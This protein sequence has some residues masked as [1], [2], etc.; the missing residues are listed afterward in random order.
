MSNAYAIDTLRPTATIV[1]AD[2][3]L[4]VGETSLVTISFSEA[5]SG[6]TTSDFFVANG[7]L[8]DLSSSDGGITWTA[9]L[10]PTVGV[11][12]TSNL[13]TLNNSGYADAAGNTGSDI[14]DSNSYAIDTLRPT[15]SIVV[16]DTALKAGDSAL[17]T[18][19]FNEAVTGLDLADFSVEH[20]ALSDLTS[21]DG[22]RTWK[23]TFTPAAGHTSTGNVITLNN[24]GYADAAGNSGMGTTVSTAYAVDTIDPVA[25]EIILDQATLVDGLRVS[26]TGLVFVSDLEPGGSWRYSLDNGASW[27]EGRGNTVQLPGLGA[28]S[29]WV[30][31]K[32]AAGNLSAVTALGGIVE[33]LVPPVVQLP[34]ISTMNDALAGLGL[35]PFQPS[36]VSEPNADFLHAAST[37]F[38]TSSQKGGVYG[39]ESWSGY[40]VPQSIAGINDWMWASIFSQAE[41]SRSGFD[42]ALEQFSVSAGANILDLN[43]ILLA[44]D[45]PWDIGSLQFSFSGKQ[46]LPSWV[47]LDPHTGQLTINAPKDL[48]TTLV[49]QI[50]V[51]DGKG[52]ESVRTIKLVVGDARSA[53]SV[54]TG[55]AG[56]SEKMANATLQQAGKRMSMYVHG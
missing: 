41:P 14:T 22:G 6:L 27:I 23:A 19:T 51:S 5:V 20:G 21:S 45:R 9:T 35:T 55:R 4:A 28:F 17:V 37:A 48:S 54:P 31:Q 44:S 50:K 8:S 53:S 1:V 7:N 49:L 26:P 43:P 36:E 56:L 47:R 18:I 34:S 38:N 46:E 42:A 33:P 12:N 30:Q 32:D 13:I 15:A 52:H 39:S 3:T 10:T 16:D 11:T 24:T 25:P 40:G 2:T 29:L